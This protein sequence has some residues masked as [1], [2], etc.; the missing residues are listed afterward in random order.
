M[1]IIGH[2]EIEYKPLYKIQNIKDISL[3]PSN[4]TVVF[5]FDFALAKHCLKNGIDY[6]IIVKNIKEV[7]FASAL[8]ATFIVTSEKKLTKKAQK[9]ATEYLFDSKIL[10]LCDDEDEMLWCAKRSIDGILLKN[11]IV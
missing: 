7:L 8:E 2:K 4:S 11:A 6:A 3:T 1:I 9:L 10:F 5:E